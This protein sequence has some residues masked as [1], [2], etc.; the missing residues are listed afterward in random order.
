MRFLP[1]YFTREKVESIISRLD[2]RTLKI[3]EL[4]ECLIYNIIV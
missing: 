3:E 1:L 2:L 4:F